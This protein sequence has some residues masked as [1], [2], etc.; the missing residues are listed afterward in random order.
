MGD[1]KDTQRVIEDLKLIKAAIAKS[2]GIMRWLP[3]SRVMRVVYLIMGLAVTALSGGLHLLERQYGSVAASP[4]WMRITLLGLGAAAFLVGGAFKVSGMMAAARRIRSDY[5][6]LRLVGEVY[7][8]QTVLIL[9]P[10]VAA[11]A[12][13]VGF[14]ATRGFAAYVVPA[15]AILFGLTMNA[16][17][18]VFYFRELVVSGDWLIATGLAVLFLGDRLAPLLGLVLTFGLGFIAAYVSG[19]IVSRI[20]DRGGEEGHE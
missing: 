8:T 10:F 6:L 14:L 7:T 9:V 16:L 11:G 17:V 18:G 15:L 5:T 1:G 4:A 19:P 20:D 13:V 3:V 2:G 12:G